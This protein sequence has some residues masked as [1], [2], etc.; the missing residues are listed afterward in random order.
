MCL[1]NIHDTNKCISLK[2]AIVIFFMLGQALTIGQ[3]AI[4]TQGIIS[5]SN[6]PH[7]SYK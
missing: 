6:L 5:V 7:K 3:F 1:M 4:K 2:D